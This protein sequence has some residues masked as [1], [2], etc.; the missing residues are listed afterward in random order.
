MCQLGLSPTAFPSAAE[1]L[2]RKKSS[3]SCIS[4]QQH[5]PGLNGGNTYWYK[6]QQEQQKQ[7]PTTK[8]HS[9]PTKP[10]KH[11]PQFFFQHRDDLNL[12]INTKLSHPGAYRFAPLHANHRAE[13]LCPQHPQISQL[14]RCFELT[15]YAV[16]T[17]QSDAVIAA[18][19]FLPQ[20]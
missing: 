12:L 6:K 7:N 5:M 2:Q 8:P 1:S 20:H 4:L 19:L 17:Q 11:V 16:V 10:T 9:P 13:Q 15:L 14:C 18:L 3:T